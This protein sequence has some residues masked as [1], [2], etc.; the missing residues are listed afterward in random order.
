MSFFIPI[1]MQLKNFKLLN[2]HKEVV[3]VESLS[4]NKQILKKTPM[5]LIMLT[6]SKKSLGNIITALMH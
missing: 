2:K 6:L 5:N 1:Y 4:I 3:S